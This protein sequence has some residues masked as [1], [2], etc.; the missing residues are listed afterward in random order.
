LYYSSLSC[1]NSLCLIFFCE[2]CSKDMLPFRHIWRCFPDFAASLCED[3]SFAVNTYCISLLFVQ[4][5][6]P[7]VPK[8][9]QLGEYRTITWQVV[10]IFI[11]IG[12]MNN[13]HSG[14]L[15]WFIGLASFIWFCSDQM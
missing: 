1:V 12:A 5:T 15:V 3:R 8:L 4:V 7:S 11:P 13:A 14:P 10:L 6:N 9:S 2:G